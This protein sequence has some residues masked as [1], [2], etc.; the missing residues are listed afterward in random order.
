MRHIILRH[1]VFPTLYTQRKQT[2]KSPQYYMNLYPGA[3][4]PALAAS[5]V[6]DGFHFINGQCG[7]ISEYKYI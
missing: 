4:Q 2:K 7:L 5:I 1:T 3:K 6:N